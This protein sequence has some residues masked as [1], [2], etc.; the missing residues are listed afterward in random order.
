MKINLKLI[1]FLVIFT[2][3]H[4]LFAE[5]FT[6][7]KVAEL[8]CHRIER[9]VVLRKIDE[10]YLT[11]FFQL[12]IEPLKQENSDAPRFRVKSQQFTNTENAAPGIIIDF[13]NEGRALNFNV[14]EGTKIAGPIWPIKDP[15]TLTENA[16]HYILDESIVIPDLLPYL[17]SL[18][19][20]TI[21]QEIIDNMSLAKVK[22]TNT[23]NN[24]VLTIFINSDGRFLHYEITP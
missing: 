24:N 16:L 14:L 8:A 10:G 7:A 2:L 13:N 6:L 9:L 1:S 17:N 23:E 12:K 3:S 19:E 18:S 4:A 20:I 15:V 21:N 11:N 22:F 5:D